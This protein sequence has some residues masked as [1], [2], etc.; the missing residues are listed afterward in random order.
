MIPDWLSII[1]LV[2]L[3]GACYACF[4]WGKQNGVTLAID[5]L[6]QEKIISH[7]DLEK[8]EK[9]QEEDVDK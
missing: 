2:W 8:L 4:V 6:L 9:L 1:E 5:L 3:V 7:K